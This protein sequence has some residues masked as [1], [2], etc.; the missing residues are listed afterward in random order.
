MRGPTLRPSSPVSNVTDS[1][2]L[3]PTNDRSSNESSDSNKGKNQKFEYSICA[4]KVDVPRSMNSMSSN[5]IISN[6]VYDLI[7]HYHY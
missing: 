2:P 1:T 7:Y 6:L 3:I 4:S 5:I